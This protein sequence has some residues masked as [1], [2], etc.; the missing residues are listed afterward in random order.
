[1]SQTLQWARH[2]RR[3]YIIV[4]LGMIAATLLAWQVSNSAGE[5]LALY[6]L[7]SRNRA[8]RQMASA[9]LERSGTR[10]TV[11]RL[12][13][14]IEASNCPYYVEVQ[15][16][17]T[18]GDCVSLPR[19]MCECRD[20]VKLI[21]KVSSRE[22][23]KALPLLRRLM[24]SERRSTSAHA[25]CVLGRMGVVARTLAPDVRRLLMSKASVNRELIREALLLIE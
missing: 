1:M 10:K 5:E 7:D 12:F 4:A 9:F 25:L 16:L 11:Q 17:L 6:M 21:V 8:I 18:N 24:Y 15:A 22:N 2:K 20:I 14:R 3:C 23:A 19:T 13:E